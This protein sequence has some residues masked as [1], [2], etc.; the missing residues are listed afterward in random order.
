MVEMMV[1][2]MNVDGE[3]MMMV[4]GPGGEDDAQDDGNGSNDGVWR[5]K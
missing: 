2:S 5:R 4:A 1:A 3:M